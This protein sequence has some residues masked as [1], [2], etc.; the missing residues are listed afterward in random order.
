MEEKP[1]CAHSPP[2]ARATDADD[3]R[4]GSFVDSITQYI[5][6]S[7]DTGVALPAMSGTGRARLRQAWRLGAALLLALHAAAAQPQE[8]MNVLFFGVDDLRAQLH[9]MGDHPAGAVGPRMRTPNFDRLAARAL[10]LNNARVQQAVCSPTRTS[11]LT[12][13]RPDTTRVYDLYTYFRE[14]APTV[15]TIPQIFKDVLNY[16]TIGMGKLFHPG[17]ASGANATCPVQRCGDDSL[18]SWSVPYWHAPNLD[19]WSGTRGS[20]P[21]QHHGFDAGDAWAAVPDAVREQHPLPDEQIADHAVDVLGNMTRGSPPWFLGVGFHKP[22][23]P[24]IFPESYVGSRLHETA[25]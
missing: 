1:R 25:Q 6:A 15:H 16:T 24:F 9:F 20:G 22:H 2:R 3:A 4:L 8:P 10:R 11:L 23:L 12:S 14:F 17:H 21:P 5:I 7:V 13:R 19:Y 18:Y